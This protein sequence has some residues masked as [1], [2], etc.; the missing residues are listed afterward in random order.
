[1]K[2]LG[3]MLFILSFGSLV[4]LAVPQTH[5]KNKTVAPLTIIGACPVQVTPGT[6]YFC[7]LQA[8]GGT[9]PFDWSLT[10]GALPPWAHGTVSTTYRP[11]DTFTITGQMPAPPPNPP[12]GLAGQVAGAM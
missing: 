2:K 10:A 7:R 5:V 6:P 1:V 11:G 4:L 8:T 3:V 12:T 9:P